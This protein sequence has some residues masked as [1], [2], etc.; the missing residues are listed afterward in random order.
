MFQAADSADI[1]PN[2]IDLP[3]MQSGTIARSDDAPQRAS[4][5]MNKQSHAARHLNNKTFKKT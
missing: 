2:S 4:M 3:L 5:A 1:V